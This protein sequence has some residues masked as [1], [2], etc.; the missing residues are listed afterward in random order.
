MAN[1]RNGRIYRIVT[2]NHNGVYIGSCSHKYLAQRWANHKCDYLHCRNKTTAWELFDTG[3]TDCKLELIE[4]FPC[5]NSRELKERE[6]YWMKT[7]E[8]CVNTNRARTTPEERK[9]DNRDRMNLRYRT[10]PEFREQKRQY[11]RDNKEACKERVRRSM[12]KR[13]LKEEYAAKLAL[14]EKA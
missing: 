10:D 2:P 7:T 6:N 11:Y 5:E 9:K 13:K 8:N 12:A 14:L 3:L 1:Y 4:D